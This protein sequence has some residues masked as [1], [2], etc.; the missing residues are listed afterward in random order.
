MNRLWPTLALLLSLTAAAEEAAAP[1]NPELDLVASF[2]ALP[3]S[4]DSELNPATEPKVSLGRM[5]FYDPRLS[6]NHDVSCNSCHDLA[7]FG[8]DGKR[9]S[10]GHKK[11]LGGRNSPTVYNAGAHVA[12]FWD[13]RAETLEDQASGPMMNP[14][15]M[16]M[17]DAARVVATL[18][19]IPAYVEAFQ[20][21]FPGEADPVTVPNAAKAIGA[22]ERGLVTPSRFDQYVKGNLK[23]LTR[24]EKAGLKTFVEVGCTTCHNGA[25][26]GGTSFQK[27]GLVEPYPDES[28]LG[29]FGITKDEADRMKFRVP[30]LRNVEKTGPYFH[31]GALT[32]LD[33]VVRSMA[34]HQLG[35]KLSKAQVTSIVAFLKALTGDLPTAY[36]QKPEL[37]KSAQATPKPDPT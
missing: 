34:R 12:Q 17:P 3:A 22:F 30:S 33:E 9:F 6:K 23:A 18:K 2:S 29:R 21:A 28:D 37:P 13:G 14:V 31:N 4:F 25:A 5:L 7:R 1:P 27:L 19:S 10:T 35:Q 20:K 11:Q 16:A 32:K 15:E 26:V 24:V 36:I 8:V